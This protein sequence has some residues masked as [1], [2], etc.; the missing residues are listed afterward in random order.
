MK[1]F[2]EWDDEYL[3]KLV[4]RVPAG[5]YGFTGDP[6]TEM[7]Q[8]LPMKKDCGLLGEIKFCEWVKEHR[9]GLEYATNRKV[10]FIGTNDIYTY[11]VA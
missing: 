9:Y 3:L 5:E 11:I 4:K 1:N 2:F 6:E 10:R 7:F 8:A